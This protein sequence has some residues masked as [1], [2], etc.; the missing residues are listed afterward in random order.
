MKIHLVNHKHKEFYE[1]GKQPL[2]SML[3]SISK[4]NIYSAKAIACIW[5]NWKGIFYDLLKFGE[6]VTVDRWSKNV[7]NK[8]II[9]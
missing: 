2:S 9:K 1:K 4:L 5:W 7:L 8:N 6:T 3:T